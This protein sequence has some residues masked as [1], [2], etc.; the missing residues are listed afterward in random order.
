MGGGHRDV[1]TCMY[2]NPQP[3]PS[4]PYTL[5]PTPY[6]LH[7][8]PYTLYPTPYTLYPTPYT[9]KPAP[10][11]RRVPQKV[12]MMLGPDSTATYLVCFSRHF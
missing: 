4:A 10:A 3:R 12:P 6:T 5:H 2:C 8:T 11:E 7:P 9:P 1:Y